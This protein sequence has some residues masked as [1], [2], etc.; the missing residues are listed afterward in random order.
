MSGDRVHLA[1]Y[2]ALDAAIDFDRPFRVIDE[3]SI[4]FP[5]GIY[6][7][8]CYIDTDADGY[9]LPDAEADLIESL[10]H[11]GWEPVDGYSGQDRYSGP[12][13]HASE[14]LGGGM[15]RDVMQT[16]G[17]YIVQA[18]ECLGPD[19]LQESPAGWI[20]LRRRHGHGEA[21]L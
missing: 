17:T 1:D 15:A 4:D 21:G 9:L 5:D 19:E 10:R 12:I 20:L 11:Q 8:D 13:M 6:A 3:H 2:Q 14:T 16:P 18:V 7:A